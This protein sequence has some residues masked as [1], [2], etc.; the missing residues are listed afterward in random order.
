MADETNTG[1]T[2]DGVHTTQNTGTGQ[3]GGNPSGTTGQQTSNGNVGGGTQTTSNQTG[4]NVGGGNQTGGAAPAE[5]QLPEHLRESLG[6]FIKTQDDVWKQLDYLNKLKGQKEILPIDYSKATQEEIT[7][8]HAKTAAK[9]VSNYEVQSETRLGKAVAEAFKTAGLSAYQGKQ[10]MQAIR[11][12]MQEEVSPEG[13]EKISK[14]VFGEK[15]L[16]VRKQSAEIMKGA[17]TDDMI[18][19]IDTL[20]NEYKVAM[21]SIVLSIKTKLEKD[22]GVRSGGA[23]PSGTSSQ[24]GVADLNK[25]RGEIFKQISAMKNRPHS[26]AE[27]KSLLDQLNAT[28]RG[29]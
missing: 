19:V 22:Y 14:E 10:I 29:A 20:P 7:A 17:L 27:K 15:Y 5:F 21:D 12:I 11:P 4:G 2:T 28:F 23:S 26:E 13:Y 1:G 9:D 25:Q 16:D 6:S 18:K 8:Y 24:I 3:T